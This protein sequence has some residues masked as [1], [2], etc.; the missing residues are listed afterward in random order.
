MEI[1][2]LYGDKKYITINLGTSADE[3]GGLGNMVILINL[4]INMKIK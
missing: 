4:K 1:L 3:C 2:K